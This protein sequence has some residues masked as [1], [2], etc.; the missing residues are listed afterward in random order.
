MFT[1]FFENFCFKNVFFCKIDLNRWLKKIFKSWSVWFKSNSPGSNDYMNWFSYSY[2]WIFLHYE[3]LIF[4]GRMKMWGKKSV[5]LFTYWF[6]WVYYVKWNLCFYLDGEE[7]LYILC[8][9]DIWASKRIN[10]VFELCEI[11]YNWQRPVNVERLL[12]ARQSSACPAGNCSSVGRVNECDAWEYSR[13][14]LI[15]ELYKLYL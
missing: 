4:E 6:Y 7:R 12:L 8:P 14:H 13:I 3:D 1:T 10:L 15:F 11:K 5:V 9:F 2:N